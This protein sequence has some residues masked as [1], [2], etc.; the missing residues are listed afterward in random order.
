MWNCPVQLSDS[1]VSE[2]KARRSRLGI[3]WTQKA[4]PVLE[5]NMETV[6]L[7][8]SVSLF[9]FRKDPLAA[10]GE[11]GNRPLGRFTTTARRFT[12][13]NPRCS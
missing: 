4:A 10:P 5:P 6:L 8:R 12:R 3:F 1:S 11:A 7:D 9:E 13:S 2:M